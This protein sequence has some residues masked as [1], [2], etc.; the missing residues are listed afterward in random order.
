QVR[1]R[2]SECVRLLE[3]GAVIEITK[4]GRDATVSMISAK[5]LERLDKMLALLSAQATDWLAKE[6]ASGLTLQ[7]KL[8]EINR[9]KARNK[10]IGEL[11]IR[12]VRELFDG[13]PTL[14]REMA[15]K[16]L[17]S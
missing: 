14:L 2:F 3:T 7:A 11:M 16:Y 9:I 8:A 4:H 15:T 13:D 17:E 10:E 1:N 12:A 5:D 6:E